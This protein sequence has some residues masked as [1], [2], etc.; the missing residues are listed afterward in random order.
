MTARQKPTLPRFT[1]DGTR[2]V[3]ESNMNPFRTNPDGGR[4]IFRIQ[5]DR[6]G[7]VQVTNIPS[8]DASTPSITADG[9]T[10]V[11]YSS[12]SIDGQNPSGNT[13]IFGINADGTGVQ[14]LTPNG[15]SQ[16]YR[17]RTDGTGLQRVSTDAT[18]GDS[19]PEISGTGTRI[20][21]VSL[22]ADP[23]G[24]NPNHYDQLVA[25][26]TSVPGP[27]DRAA[28]APSVC[29]APASAHP[30]GARSGSLGSSLAPDEPG[31]P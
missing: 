22:G 24:S 25:A 26:S 5:A 7:L 12:A 8:G 31:E 14:R 19:S 29:R 10:I 11:F 6:T 27:G 21:Y 18:R 17:M 23:V 9:N 28:V 13:D 2:V 15:M 4:E 1:R 3:F 20:V 30:E 16:I